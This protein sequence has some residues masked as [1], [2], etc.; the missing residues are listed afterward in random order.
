[1]PKK[2]TVL[3]IAFL[4]GMG[5]LFASCAGMQTKP[6]AANF[7]N[8]VVA[9]ELVEV[10]Q[11]DGYW[12]YGGNIKPTKGKA[13]GHGAPL[14]VAITFNIT[15]PNPYPV[16]LEGY[17]F[18]LAFEGFELITVNG[19]ETQWIPAGKTNQLRA[20]TLITSMS[21]FIILGAVSGHQIKAKGMDPWSAI[22]KWWTTIEDMAFPIN[23]NDGNF[24][25][26]A[27]GVSK[28]IPFKG[29]YPE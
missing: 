27:N 13:G 7:K 22:E 1:M 5:V 12:Y 23:I 3:L 20:S 8:P 18:S 4:F 14:P 9:I 24:S 19:Y 25:F 21:A 17:I 16:L 26:K 6:T 10:P 28:V 29:T 11:F 15:N 2:S